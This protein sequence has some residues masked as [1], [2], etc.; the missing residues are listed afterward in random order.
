[1][2]FGNVT[3][4]RG[5]MPQPIYIYMYISEDDEYS[6]QGLFIELNVPMRMRE[7]E[8]MFLP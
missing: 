4:C 3:K 2:R 8:L 5:D 1:M 7:V 6:E